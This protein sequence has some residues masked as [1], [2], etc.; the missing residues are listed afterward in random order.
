MIGTDASIAQL[1]WLF[2]INR[3][4][5]TEDDFEVIRSLGR[6]TYPFTNTILCPTVCDVNSW[7]KKKIGYL[8]YMKLAYLHPNVFIAD[9]SILRKYKI[10]E[11][12]VLIRLAKLTAHHD[13]GVKGIDHEIL[14]KLIKRVSEEKYKVF[15]SSE[16]DIPEKYSAYILKIIPNDL[17]NILASASLLVSDSQSMSVEA[18]MLGVPSI[19]LSDFAGRISVLEELEFKYQL[20]FGIKPTNENLISERL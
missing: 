10:S 17:H 13:F 2:R 20:T 5:I 15:I 18:A 12:F 11:K 6:L 8:G 14:D 16:G 7:E 3:I 19:R 1:G 4:T 9:T